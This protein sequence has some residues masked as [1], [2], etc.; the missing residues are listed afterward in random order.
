[1]GLDCTLNLSLIW[2]H[3]LIDIESFKG[4]NHPA[5]V[6]NVCCVHYVVYGTKGVN[7]LYNMLGEFGLNFSYF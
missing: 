1:M 4:I 2:V 6:C 3:F 5:L 7:F